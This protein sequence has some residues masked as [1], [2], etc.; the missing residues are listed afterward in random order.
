MKCQDFEKRLELLFDD[1]TPTATREELLAHLKECPDCQRLYAQT[2]EALEAVTPRQAIPVPSD[3]K[4]RILRAAT[5]ETNEGRKR[6]ASR[7]R[8][9]LRPLTASLS[10]AALIALVLIFNPIQRYQAHAAGRLLRDAIAQIENSQSF[11]LL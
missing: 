1:N 4:Q 5:D 6:T 3:L 10:A 2:K 11:Y 9:W 7:R 8:R